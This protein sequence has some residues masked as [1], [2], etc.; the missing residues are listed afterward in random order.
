MSKILIKG[1]YG[2][3]NLGDDF[4]LYSILDILNLNGNHEVN[5]ISAGNSDYSDFFS[6]FANLKCHLVPQSRWRKFG[7]LTFLLKSKY[8][9]IGGGGI[10]AV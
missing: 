2:Q 7:K 6:K 1:F 10:M 3:N 5:I 4:I 9:I 8:W